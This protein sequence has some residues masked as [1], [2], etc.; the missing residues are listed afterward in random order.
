MKILIKSGRIINPATGMDQIS[1]LLVDNGLVKQINRSISPAEVG[2]DVKVIDAEGQ[3]VMPGFIDVHIH[4][5]EPGFEYKETIETGTLSALKGGVTTVCPMPNTK[6]TTDSVE[7]VEYIL[8]KAKTEGH[9]HV[10]PIGAITMGQ[11]GEVLTDLAALKKAGICAISEDGRSVMAAGKLKA[12]MIEAKRL[13]IPVLSHCEDD[14]LAHGGCMNEGIVSERLGLKG[15]PNDAEDVITARDIILAA[16]TGAQLHL[17]H[18]STAGSVEIIRTAKAKGIQ[19]T[20][21]VAPHHFVLTEEAVTGDNSNTKMNPPLRTAADVEAMKAGLVDGTIDMIATDHAPH[22]P[23]EKSG[24]YAKAANGIVGLETSA[25]LTYT[26]LVKTGLLTPMQMAEKMSLNPAKMLG[27]DKGN[28]AVGCA[29][30]IVVFDPEVTYKIDASK[31]SSKSKNTPYDGM[32]VSGM[33]MVTIVDGEL[34]HQAARKE[35]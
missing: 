25:A 29:A 35:N 9:V 33:V 22:A 30:D 12:A 15:I 18:V 31:L 11:Q 3:W 32:A 27:I 14:S 8:N 6:P 7:T 10:L 34:R 4:L 13:G 17:C 20:A 19:V 5:R 16:S 28:I 2:Y 23:E 1:D 21:E 26:H 24:D